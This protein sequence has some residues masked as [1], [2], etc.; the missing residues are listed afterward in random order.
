MVP[1]ISPQTFAGAHPSGQGGTNLHQFWIFL[2]CPFRSSRPRIFFVV[3][4]FKKKQKFFFKII[5][6]LSNRKKINLET[7]KVALHLGS[8]G[9][10]E[11]V[12]WT[13]R[14]EP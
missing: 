1:G 2:S 12:G 7:G 9:W 8:H 14:D 13:G 10:A 4:L 11:V 6:Y 3:L 5:L